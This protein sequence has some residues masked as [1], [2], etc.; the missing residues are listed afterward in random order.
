M[1]PLGVKRAIPFQETMR[2]VVVAPVLERM[3]TMFLA[4]RFRVP[5]SC[6]DRFGTAFAPLPSTAN[7]HLSNP[8]AVG[9]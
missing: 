5:N 2:V 8:V 4:A 6:D 7:T 3:A 9:A 1:S